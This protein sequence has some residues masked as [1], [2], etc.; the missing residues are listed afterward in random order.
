M[1]LLETW[2]ITNN[3]TISLSI[4]DILTPYKLRP[5]ETIDILTVG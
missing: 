5:G 4:S 1:S 3:H 2:F